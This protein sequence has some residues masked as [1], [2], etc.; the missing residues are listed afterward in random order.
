MQGEPTL[1]IT[2]RVTR[3]DNYFNIEL[4]I[5]NKTAVT[6]ELTAIEDN[7]VGFQNVGQGGIGGVVTL[8]S[9]TETS[10]QMVITNL[11]FTLNHSAESGHDLYLEL[12]GDP[13]FI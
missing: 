5:Q 11:D 3:M 1:E 13:D 8:K 12:C 9:T 6:V 7:M 2:R 4:R 10:N